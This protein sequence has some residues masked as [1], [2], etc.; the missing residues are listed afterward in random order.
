MI[1]GPQIVTGSYDTHIFNRQ[2]AVSLTHLDT[3]ELCYF[4]MS[5]T[6]LRL[7]GLSSLQADRSI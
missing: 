6:L 7:V 2:P 4:E 1:T 5:A 3:R